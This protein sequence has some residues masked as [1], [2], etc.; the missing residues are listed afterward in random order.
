VQVPAPI[1]R[2]SRVADVYNSR[3]EPRVL[4]AGTQLSDPDL[5]PGETALKSDLDLWRGAG[6]SEAVSNCRGPEQ[7]V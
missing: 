1:V 5:V 4:K 7:G 2:R 3:V 6:G